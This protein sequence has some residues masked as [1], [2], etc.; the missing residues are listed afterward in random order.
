MKNKLIASAFVLSAAFAHVM[1]SIGLVLIAVGGETTRA[2]GAV[3]LLVSSLACGYFHGLNR[4][5]E[6]L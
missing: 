2:L 5:H 6:T 4:T 1:P 3:T